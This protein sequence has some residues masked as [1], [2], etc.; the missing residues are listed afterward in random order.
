LALAPLPISQQGRWRAE[1]NLMDFI[2]TLDE[3]FNGFLFL[4]TRRQWFVNEKGDHV[5]NTAPESR[6][7]AQA[8]EFGR[9]G[10]LNLGS[11]S[12]YWNRLPD[13]TGRLF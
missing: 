8:R 13:A 3:A 9:I 7:P 4:A 6:T 11:P 5:R 1:L 2:E 10:R 12:E